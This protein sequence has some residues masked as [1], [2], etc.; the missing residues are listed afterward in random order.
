MCLCVN[1]QWG[2]LRGLHGEGEEDGKKFRHE[3]CEKE[4]EEGSESGEWDRCAAKVIHMWIFM[5]LQLS[6]LRREHRRRIAIDVGGFLDVVW[7]E[8]M[9]NFVIGIK[10]MS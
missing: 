9:W 1:E 7:V 3:V 4:T 10:A 6:S 2:I 8:S 5:S